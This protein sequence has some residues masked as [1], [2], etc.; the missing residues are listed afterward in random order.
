ME[1]EELDD[2]QGLFKVTFDL[3]FKATLTSDG[4]TLENTPKEIWVIDFSN[5]DNP[6]IK[7]Y[8]VLV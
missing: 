1:V 4:A 7:E 3:Y 6:L 2:Q 5:S 8:N